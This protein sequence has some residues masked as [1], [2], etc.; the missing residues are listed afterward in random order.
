M[1]IDYNKTGNII[2]TLR[3]RITLTQAQLGERLGVSY[4]AVS[5]WERGECLPDVSLLVDLANILETTVDNILCAGQ[6]RAAYKGKISIS[7]AAEGIRCIKRMGELLGRDNIIYLNA[8]RGI[9]EGLNTD[10]EEAFANENIFEVFVAETL[11]WS[12]GDGHY[13]DLTDISRSFKSEKLR[14][15]LTDAAKKH[16]IV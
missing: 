4:Q 13:V 15:M 9:N 16:G 1:S 2:S 10:V 3:Q 11:L 8:I 12:I 5:K 14:I 6:T 7:D